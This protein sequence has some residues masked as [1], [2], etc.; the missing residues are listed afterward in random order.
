MEYK[1]GL[2][3]KEA[4]IFAEENGQI[5]LKRLC[6]M[7]A[8][9]FKEIPARLKGFFSLETSLG[10]ARWDDF[11]LVESI[12]EPDKARL[13]WRLYGGK[14]LIESQNA[15]CGKTGVW[16][17]KDVLINAGGEAVTVYRF[18]QRYALAPGRYEVYS[19]NNS[20]RRENQGFWQ[21]LLH[22]GL[23]YGCAGGCSCDG[24]TPFLCL[25]EAGGQKGS[26]IAFHIMPMGN[27]QINVSAP[28]NRDMAHYAAVELGLSDKN[29]RLTLPAGES[30]ETPEILTLELTEGDITSGA[31]MLHQFLLGEML[32][33]AKETAPVVY[34]TWFDYNEH[35]DAGRLAEQLESAKE[36]GCEV[37]V[38][39][40]G[41]F[42]CGDDSWG[43]QVGDWREKKNGAFFGHMQEFAEKVRSAG[44]G[45]GLWMEP[46]RIGPD[47][48]ILAERPLWFL[49][50]DNGFYYPDLTNPEAY[51]YTLGEMSRLTESYGLAWM[52]VDFNFNF[53]VDSRGCEYKDYYEAWFRLIDELK[54]RYPRVFYEGCASGGQR[55]DIS[56]L[57]HF[58]GHFLSDNTNPH[59]VISMYQGA[60]L[61]LPPGRIT[62]WAVLRSVTQDIPF[63]GLAP[64]SAP[65]RVIS[66]SETG[67][68]WDEF[69]VVN[70]DFAVLSAMPG[71]FGLSGDI[72]SLPEYEMEKLKRH[73]AFY[74]KW[75]KLI[76]NSAAHLLSPPILQGNYG[77]W[78]AMQ[79]QNPNNTESLLFVYRLEN[80]REK[81]RFYLRNLEAG[82][83]Y[84]V[85]D[86]EGEAVS[87]TASGKLLMEEG[88]S[89]IMPKR[90]DAK[91]LVITRAE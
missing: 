5:Y 27:W 91:V 66:P 37:F 47:A 78:A 42:G 18:Q 45:F 21:P 44:L 70:L 39:D 2:L 51:A 6:G 17:R 49:P 54:A 75:R 7:D 80:P 34:N 25:R 72:R 62:K 86:E 55:A 83:M 41:W 88:I 28:T 68:A 58:D 64:G 85:C 73:I 12:W 61:R 60:A 4:A 43:L 1:Y 16:S 40:A 50:A 10:T 26:G 3:G 9:V 77:G 36:A 35:L 82:C 71:M 69:S 31:Y 53:G 59:S 20:W 63:Y 81:R 38:I 67:I 87:E 24:G 13:V 57:R 32:N 30:L 29:L 90:N 48:P 14:L 11:E 33:Q 76:V 65:Q 74:K 8:G 46:E 84:A 89:V 19:Q 52:K 15:F 79:L 56:A 23:S 22:G